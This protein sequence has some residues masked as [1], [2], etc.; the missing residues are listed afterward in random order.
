MARRTVSAR[1]CKLE[2]VERSAQVRSCP[3][4]TRGKM[5][6]WDDLSNSRVKLSNWSSQSGYVDWFF[7]HLQAEQTKQEILHEM[8]SKKIK[9]QLIYRRCIF[10]FCFAFSS[11]L[12]QKVNF[13]RVETRLGRLNLGQIEILRVSV[14][15]KYR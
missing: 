1:P 15:Y 12:F 13:L 6:E 10:K 5:C 11:F 4:L 8:W 2:V 3:L 7:Y 9:L 14:Y